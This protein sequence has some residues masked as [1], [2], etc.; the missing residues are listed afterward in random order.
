[1]RQGPTL[2]ATDVD[3]VMCESYDE[4][5]VALLEYK[6]F[7][8]RPLAETGALLQFR[9]LADMAQLPGFIVFYTHEPYFWVRSWNFIAQQREGQR[10]RAMDERDFAEWL[11]H[12][13]GRKLPAC[14]PNF[15]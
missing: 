10:D 7:K 9:N 1:M 2:Y 11:Y 8:P 6:H 4:T 5:P 3:V 15:R 14:W 13:R 12:L